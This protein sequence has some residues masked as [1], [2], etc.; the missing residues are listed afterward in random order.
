MKWTTDVQPAGIG[1]WL[2]HW[3]SFD[4][5]GL[6]MPIAPKKPH[7]RLHRLV[8]SKTAEAGPLWQKIKKGT[9]VSDE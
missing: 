1:P 5:D 7:P 6:K 9:R 8:G 3:L 2:V 4:G